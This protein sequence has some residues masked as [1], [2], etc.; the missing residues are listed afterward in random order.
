MYSVKHAAA[1]TGIPVD[2][3]RMWERRY[4]V[5][6][7]LR[8][9]AG[10]RLYDD[11]A[12]ARLSAMQ[13]LVKAGWAPRRAAVQVT[14][15]TTLGPTDVTDASTLDTEGAAEPG[16]D[17]DLLVSLAV[18]FDA[19]RLTRALDDIFTRRDL[20]EMADSWLMPALSR[21]GTAWQRGE[22][23]VAAEHFVSAAVQRR[24]ASAFDSAHAAPGA[25]RVLVGLAKG[26]RHELGVLTFATMLARA[27][28][29]VTYIGADVPPDSWAIAV[30]V[31]QP[32]AVV[33]GVPSTDDLPVVRDT[34]AV[35][36]A[37]EPDLPTFLVGRHQSEVGTGHLLGHSLAS[38]AED[39]ARQLTA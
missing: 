7:P 37:A 13:A 14:S 27:G 26:S 23:S 10:Y 21:L 29:D 28:L 19:E 2:T 35:I 20:E 1:M 8:T 6:T 17:L 30:T 34:V 9:P 39:L 25:P 4:G 15:G 16:D 3:L 31:G 38:A 18:D 32:A 36:A 24:L 12:I 11:A 22:V 5:V 33:L